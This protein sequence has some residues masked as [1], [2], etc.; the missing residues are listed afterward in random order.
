MWDE[1]RSVTNSAGWKPW[2]AN[3]KAIRVGEIILLV[4]SDTVVPEVGYNL[5][6]HNLLALIFYPCRTVFVMPLVKWPTHLM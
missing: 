6:K 4:D 1:S 2:A 5:P 3:G